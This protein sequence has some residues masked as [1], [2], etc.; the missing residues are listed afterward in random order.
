[1]RV[2]DLP[3]AGLCNKHLLAQHNE[4]HAIF[5]IITKEKKGYA[6]HPEVGRWRGR[7]GVDALG[8][9]HEA[10][11]TEMLKRGYQHHSY[12]E[13]ACRRLPPTYLQPLCQQLE[14][15]KQKQSTIS[16]CDCYDRMNFILKSS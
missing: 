8:Q 13:R 16:G 10:T 9:K 1:M 4:I 12:M 11:I 5:S 14:I 3:V 6:H 7:F 15:L 2:W